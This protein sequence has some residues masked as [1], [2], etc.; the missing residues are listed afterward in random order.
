[1]VDE[2][3]RV[4]Q[5]TGQ[6]DAVGGDLR[7]DAGRCLL[8]GAGWAVRGTRRA[9]RC[10]YDVR[11]TRPTLFDPERRRRHARDAE[12]LVAA[13]LRALGGL[14]EIGQDELTERILL[15]VSQQIL[16][17]AQDV[18]RADRGVSPVIP[19]GR[20]LGVLQTKFF[21]TIL[22]MTSV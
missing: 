12:I 13:V 14:P 22:V 9:L 7:G 6:I 10:A 5:V 18:R 1:M 11:E 2:A 16:V 21:S 20:R 15:L 3:S 19:I 8:A 4:Q 17:R